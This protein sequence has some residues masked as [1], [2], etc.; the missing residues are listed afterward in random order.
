MPKKVLLIAGGAGSVVIA[1]LLVFWVVHDRKPSVANRIQAPAPISL[2]SDPLQQRVDVIVA[3]YRKTIV[4]LEEDDSLPEADRETASIVGR[5]IFQENHEDISTLSDELTAGM[6]NA[7]DWTRS[8]ANVSHFLDLVETQED[9]HDADKL[10]FREIF[11]DIADSLSGLKISAPAKT[12]LQQRVEEDRQALAEIQSLYEKELDKIFGRFATRGMTVRREAWDRY[13]AYLHTKY[14]REEILKSYESTVKSI[15]VSAGAG[16]QDNDLEIYG[17]KL[18]PKTLVLTF[19][20]GPHPRYT[21]R[22]LDILRQ[23]QIKSV[24]FELGVNL[25]T[26][27]HDRIQPT[28]AASA[29]R[30]LV[31][32]GYTIGSHGFSHQVLPKMSDREIGAEIDQTNRLLQAVDNVR[33]PLF[34]P[35]YGERDTKVLA[36]IEAHRM[37]SILWNIDSKDWADPIAKSI[38]NRVIAGARRSG[39]GIILLHDI[40]ERT[41]DALPLI[42][43]TLRADGYRFL[44]W[45]GEGFVEEVPETIT[46]AAPAADPPPALYRESWA[47]I[48][49]IDDYAKWPKLQYAVNDATGIRD[50]LL[51][52]FGFKNDHI[53]TLLNEEA[54]RERILSAL[55]DTLSDPN[56]VHRDDRVFVFFAGHG[57][58]RRLPSGRDLGYIIPWDADTR[59]FEGQ[60]ISMTSFQDI[61]ESIPAKH[62]FFV[63]DSC[64]SGLGITRGESA[65][66][67][68]REMARRTAR[69][70]LTA[71]GANE[72]VADNGP[73]GHSVF[74]WTL[75]QGL[76]GRADLNSDGFIT[77]AELAA[78]V[79][80]GVSALSHQTPAFGNLPGAEGGEF[81]FELHPE[82]EA[83]SRLSGQL[84]Q[85]AIQLNAQLDQIR[86][87]IAD[88][89]ARNNE[90]RRQIAAAQSQQAASAVLESPRQKVSAA[91]HLNRGDA[92]FKEKRYQEALDEFLTAAK[93]DPRNALAANN[94]G[95][96][97]SKLQRFDESIEWTRKAIEIDPKRAVAYQNLGD[98]YY[99]LNRPEDARLYYEK[100]LELAGDKP[101]AGAVRARLGKQ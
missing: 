93:M 69:Q 52:K 96:I 13:V 94:V 64:Y 32:A 28:R 6:L 20:D 40:H 53:I 29:S 87:Q 10:V 81:I 68:L 24:F 3:R 19:D 25:A 8:P 37:R 101:Y 92:L 54:T 47:V 39:H 30:R 45:N 80:P 36:A 95:F 82:T 78:Y 50:I 46:V 71:G 5:L 42:I 98:L 16:H 77:A 76:E 89:T 11:T 18:P 90:L 44:A 99:Q 41:I 22:I 72:E 70:M 63:M 33:T 55:G 1:V 60:A 100:Y 12:E 91:T 65:N 73:N 97:Y 79:G 86:K 15:R 62:V 85:E 83:L 57:T 61:S 34:R 48:A 26:V 59:N 35:P 23:H 67:Y 49:G 14:R 58:T 21:D 51:N 56:K 66:N 74:T 9:L 27:N 17:T 75:L 84:D 38:A 7:R 4:L 2:P 88:K 31:E 43:E